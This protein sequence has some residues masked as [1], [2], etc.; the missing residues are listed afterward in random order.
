MSKNKEKRTAL[1]NGG[2]EYDTEVPY[3]AFLKTEGLG[4]RHS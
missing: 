4:Y 2:E 3:I 1:V